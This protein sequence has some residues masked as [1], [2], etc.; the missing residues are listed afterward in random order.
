MDQYVREVDLISPEG[1]HCDLPI[2]SQKEVFWV[3][4]GYALMLLA[5]WPHFIF[6]AWALVAKA[7]FYLFSFRKP[8]HVKFHVRKAL[9]SQVPVS[10][11]SF[12]VIYIF[13]TNLS[14]PFQGVFGIWG[15]VVLAIL[16]QS[17][18]VLYSILQCKK[19]IETYNSLNKNFIKDLDNDVV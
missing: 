9:I 6:P 14:S 16:A 3:L 8:L 7:L 13:S 19:V 5:F 18:Y 17:A 4:T 12:F 15:L 2:W 10:L 1:E 11:F